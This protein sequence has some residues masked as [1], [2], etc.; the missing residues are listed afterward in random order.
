MPA[1]VFRRFLLLVCLH[2]HF[3]CN[4]QICF[5]ESF[6][7]HW[8][9]GK[10]LHR[11]FLQ[12]P[13]LD[14]NFRSVKQARF[15][16]RCYRY[17]PVAA[18]KLHQISVPILRQGSLIQAPPREAQMRHRQCRSHELCCPSGDDRIC[19]DRYQIRYRQNLQARDCRVWSW[20]PDLNIVITQPKTHHLHGIYR[21]GWKQLR[22]A[23]GFYLVDCSCRYSLNN[24]T[25]P[26][27]WH[28]PV[29]LFFWFPSILKDLWIRQRYFPSGFSTAFWFL[30]FFISRTSPTNCQFYS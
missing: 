24:F 27:H 4:G 16:H 5:P 7:Q 21:C 23:G 11:C 26:M 22:S 9:P 1:Y 20:S 8:Q 29:L 18:R 19:L 2:A 28:W 10:R 6:R 3:L 12:H 13:R 15:F 30:P 17:Y 14:W 25:Q